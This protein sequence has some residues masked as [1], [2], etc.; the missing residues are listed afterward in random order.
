MNIEQEIIEITEHVLG[1]DVDA[2]DSNETQFRDLGAD[3]LDMVDIAL[4]LEDHF[5]VYVDEEKLSEVS[6]IRDAA[7]LIDTL[8]DD[9]F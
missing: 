9:S 3:S 8:L 6:T 7:V 4:A 1:L 2:I 5:G